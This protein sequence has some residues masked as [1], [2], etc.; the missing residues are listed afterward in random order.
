MN[1]C[2]CSEDL[3]RRQPCAPRF[4]TS[5]RVPAV[6]LSVIERRCLVYLTNF[7][8]AVHYNAVGN[9]RGSG[10]HGRGDT[11]FCRRSYSHHGVLLQGTGGWGMYE[12]WVDYV[13]S[14]AVWAHLSRRAQNTLVHHE[15]IASCN[16]C[17]GVVYTYC[18]SQNAVSKF[19]ALKK[20]CT[21]R[22]CSYAQITTSTQTMIRSRHIFTLKTTNKRLI[23]LTNT[24]HGKPKGRK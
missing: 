10:D 12:I 22:L 23:R 24:K 4:L 21:S 13:N 18:G 17:M 14:S 9:H 19:T 6:V 8:A 15:N 5:L 11:T 2:F 3:F 20:E 16:H 7:V 1:T